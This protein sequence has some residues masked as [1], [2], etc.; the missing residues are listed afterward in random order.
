MVILF[1][2][3][4]P[5]FPIALHLQS[6]SLKFRHR[7]RTSFPLCRLIFNLHDPFIPLFEQLVQKRRVLHCSS[8]EGHH[9]PL[10]LLCSFYPLFHSFDVA[11]RGLVL[12]S[13]TH[14][15]QHQHLLLP[16][17]LVASVMA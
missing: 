12:L 17:E 6:Q 3:H 7:R 9:M 1:F 2:Q 13:Q 5:L 8:Q 4:V 14:Q 16:P 15:L 11:F 10:F